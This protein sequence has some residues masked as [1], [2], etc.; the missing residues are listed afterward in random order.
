MLGM[1][2][3]YLSHI[4]ILLITQFLLSEAKNFVNR[5]NS[6]ADHNGHVMRY[7]YSHI[8]KQ[9]SVRTYQAATKYCITVATIQITVAMHVAI[10]IQV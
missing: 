8:F 4:I 6:I 10:I 7:M 5:S 3:V 9:Y 1:A 2:I